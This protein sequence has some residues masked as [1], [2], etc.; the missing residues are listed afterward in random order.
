MYRS[1]PKGHKLRRAYLC[2]YDPLTTKSYEH[3]RS[4]LEIKLLK[5]ADIFSVKLC[6]YAVMSN[7]YHVV[8]H[9]RPDLAQSLTELEVVKRWQQCFNGTLLSQRFLNGEPLSD[10]Q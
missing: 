8:L 5:T 6:S 3:R 4:W 2:G 10:S 9:I 1:V 7:H